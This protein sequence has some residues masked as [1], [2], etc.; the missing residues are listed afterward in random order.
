MNG[1]WSSDENIKI[2]TFVG[3]AILLVLGAMGVISPGLER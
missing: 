3:T 2:I 1:S